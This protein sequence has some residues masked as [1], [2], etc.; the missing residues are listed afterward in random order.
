MDITQQ[1]QHAQ[2]I[3]PSIEVQNF[4][5]S[6]N[7]QL[8]KYKLGELLGKGG[9]G[10]IYRAQDQ[11]T[12]RV[13]AVKILLDKNTDNTKKLLGEASCMAQ[14][15]HPNIV[16]FYEINYQPRPFFVM[17]YVEGVPL[18][19]LIHS[20][21][22]KEQQIIDI[23]SP[24]C[25]ALSYAHKKNIL[26]R[27]IKPANIIITKDRVPK[28]TD[29]G[30]ARPRN[31]G[32]L[33][34]E[35]LFQGTPNY[36]A[37]EQVSG[38]T[39][40]KSEVYSLGATIYEML[41][42][43]PP[44]QGDSDYN[45]LFQ[46]SNHYPIRPR[47]IDPTISPYLEAICLKCLEKQPRKRYRNCKELAKDLQN[48]R[49]GLA[50]T[51]KKYTHWDS[52]RNFV[53]RHRILCTSI[54]VISLLFCLFFSVLILQNRQLN[55][56]NYDYQL[57]RILLLAQMG[58]AQQAFEESQTLF[59]KDD[60]RSHQLHAKIY[61]MVK[62]YQKAL[63]SST[64]ALEKQPNLF[65]LHVLHGEILKALNENEQALQSF[66]RAS[67]LN[68]E[69]TDLFR[70]K[71]LVYKNLQKYE[72]AL[73]EYNQALKKLPNSAT[74]Y[75][76]RGDVYFAQRN[77]TLSLQDFNKAIKINPH[78]YY[79]IR[80]RADINLL[81]G[82]YQ[83]ALEDYNY[84]VENARDHTTTFIQ[85]G[86]LHRRLQNYPKAIEDYSAAQKLNPLHVDIYHNR[87]N[88]YI[89]TKNYPLALRDA[90][91]CVLLEPRNF[92]FHLNLPRILNYQGR[93]S[94]ALERI[95]ALEK[96]VNDRP[97]LFEL[98]GIVQYNLRQYT[99]ALRSFQKAQQ[100]GLQTKELK[101]LIS[102]TRKKIA[103]KK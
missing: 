53:Q 77:F 15:E 18:S 76:L 94:Q 95:E 58:R 37:P 36:A 103:T 7:Y 83:Q 57:Q 5:K 54:I 47:E 44:F 86:A 48:L 38:K 46:V 73:S 39:S 64:Q 71:G 24:L 45:V 1:L 60:F 98:K 43:R 20:E 79:S 40:V 17:E 25:D 66:Q 42:S 89:D 97:Q 56:K 72:L 8:G 28:I 33:T 16:R 63:Q 50:I 90:Q 32:N 88:V 102:R 12:K 29:F 26:H 22:F 87:S 4:I 59:T 13:V 27:D 70:L 23:L 78:D 30:L 99:K 84:V 96:W 10:V 34:I 82:E 2:S 31:A 85:R 11:Q 69:Y 35:G 74:F 65:K 19:L 61:Y 52:L 62:K 93:F 41:T 81:L 80:K 49:K 92:R 67:V 21:T 91:I 3:S 68:P 9:M 51:A 100:L 101:A 14:L 6:H 75:A 55:K